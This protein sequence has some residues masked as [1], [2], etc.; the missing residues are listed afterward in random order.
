[1]NTYEIV[2]SVIA[3][4]TFAILLSSLFFCSLAVISG[5]LGMSSLICFLAVVESL[6]VTAWISLIGLMI[7]S[8]GLGALSEDFMSRR[9]RD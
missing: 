3:G 5:V 6:S 2:M 7:G 9:E 1:M 8:F 4:I